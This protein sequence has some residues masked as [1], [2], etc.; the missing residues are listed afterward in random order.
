LGFTLDVMNTVLFIHGTGTREPHCSE[1][2]AEVSAGLQGTAIVKL[3]YWGGTEGSRLNAGGASIPLY[4]STRSLRETLQ[5]PIPEQTSDYDIAVWD[6][7]GKAPL[8]E[9]RL[10]VIDVDREEDLT[11]NQAR[12]RLNFEGLAS[13]ETWLS[14]SS[15]LRACILASRLGT[16]LIEACQILEKSDAYRNA[17]RRSDKTTLCLTASRAI[18]AIS[19]FLADEQD[20]PAPA[21]TNPTLRD[22]LV[23][24]F[25]SVLAGL[26][27]E[28]I[29]SSRGPLKDH[30]VKP[31]VGLVGSAATN[32]VT[33]HVRRRRGAIHDAHTATAGDILLYQS[34]GSKIRRFIRDRVDEI[35]GPVVLVAHSLGGV[36][37]VDL[38][39]LE[40]LMNV[41]LLVTIGSQ[42][43][44]FY[45]LDS[46]QSLEYR[47]VRPSAR[48]PEH[49]PKWL[50][51]YDLRDFLSYVVEPVFGDTNARDVMVDN[52]LPF[53]DSH[54]GYFSNPSVWK[55]VVDAL[56][57]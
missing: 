5:R 40:K 8:I 17:A 4:N 53:P 29:E 3:C 49:F 2:V 25:S 35:D 20:T 6:L 43:S 55:T 39:I 33:N 28:T 15:E 11:P 56:P 42:A 51:I 50:N 22:K 47:T 37:C 41:A 10:L 7:L 36:A 14:V 31:L 1:I 46:L 27:V 54:G 19:F 32:L 24:G 23:D 52:R 38:L 9:L 18:V 12:I 34:R 48:L 57:R 13:W 26:H 45:E 30:L 21:R 44:L 16:F